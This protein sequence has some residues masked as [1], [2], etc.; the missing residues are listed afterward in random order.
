VTQLEKEE[1]VHRRADMEASKAEHLL[2]RPN[3]AV[4]ICLFALD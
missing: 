1:A 3:A 2:V 4:C